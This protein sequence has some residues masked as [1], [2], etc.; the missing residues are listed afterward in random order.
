[1][2]FSN[3]MIFWILIFAVIIL[4]IGIHLSQFTPLPILDKSKEYAPS[5]LFNIDANKAAERLNTNITEHFGNE[6]DLNKMKAK[7]TFKDESTSVQQEAGASEYYNW[8]IDKEKTN[9]SIGMPDVNFNTSSFDY[10]WKKPHWDSGHNK[11]R[12]SH[13]SHKTP[14]CKEP[15]EKTEREICYN[16]DITANKD[17]NK[18]V[19]KSSI[20]PCPDMANYVTKNMMKPDIDMNEYIKKSEIKPCPEV[21]MSRFVLKSEIPACPPQVVCPVCPICPKCEEPPKCKEINEFK[22]TEHPDMK[23]YIKKS[24]ILKSDIVKKYIADNFIEKS[25]CYQKPQEVKK[26]EPKK[27]ENKNYGNKLAKRLENKIMNKIGDS[28]NV[29]GL[30]AGDSLFATV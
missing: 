4:L 26:E 11:P 5:P 15:K 21:D 27:N 19:L 29:Q 10:D 22:I 28:S 17:I 24:D 12:P 6:G 1:M 18:Y 13:P 20:P 9:I 25:K 23:D 8:G 30:Y 16:C 14:E 3:Q 2:K 7:E